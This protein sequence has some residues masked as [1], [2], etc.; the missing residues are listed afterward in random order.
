MIVVAYQC[1]FMYDLQLI[2]FLI[3]SRVGKL[4]DCSIRVTRLVEISNIG[5][6]FTLVSF[7][8]NNR[9]R[10]NYDLLFPRFIICNKFDK[11]WRGR[12]FRAILSQTHLVALVF[13]YEAQSHKRTYKWHK[14]TEKILTKCYQIRTYDFMYHLFSFQRFR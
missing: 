13:I 14:K 3:T 5:R 4:R 8:Q 2:H 6:L 7:I 10:P 12:R 9:N 1:P 11:K